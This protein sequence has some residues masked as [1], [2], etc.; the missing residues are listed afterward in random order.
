MLGKLNSQVAAAPH[1]PNVIVGMAGSDDAGVYRLTDDIA[2]VQTLDFFTPI[3][4]DPYDFGRI[5]ATNALSDVWAMGGEPLTALN[6]VCFP[7]GKMDREVLH[8]ILAGGMA[9]AREAGVAL[10]GGH[11][12]SDP[13]L[14]YGMAVTGTVRPDRVLTNRGARPGDVLILTKPLGTGIVGT[15]IK[16][17]KASPEA[18]AHAVRSMTA[19]NRWPGD[20]RGREAEYVHACTDVTG[21][22]LLGHA[23][24]MLAG[25]PDDPSA[26]AAVGFEI[27]AHRVPLLT[28]ARE[29][30]AAGIKPGGLKRNREFVGASAQIDPAVAEDLADV[31]FDP[32]TSGGLLLAVAAEA[33]EDLL[34]AWQRHHASADPQAP[35]AAAVIGRVTTERPGCIRVRP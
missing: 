21:Y 11:S 5:A 14:K 24:E 15:A 22:A 6:L 31:L 9:A 28:Q 4:D 10:I 13:E 19:L 1:D 30:A 3:V 34:A 25:T 2:L 18:E 8:R 16:K 7:D 17:Q 35:L 33:A 27:E 29:L 26:P 20:W 12:V 32:Q 23:C